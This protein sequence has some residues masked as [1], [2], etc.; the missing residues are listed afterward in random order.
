[1]TDKKKK[2]DEEEEIDY[3]VEYMLNYL[4]KSMKLRMDKWNKMWSIDENSKTVLKFFDK[5]EI[6]KIIMNVNV[7]GALVPLLEFPPNLKTKS[8]YFIRRVPEPITRENI[9]DVLLIGDVSHKPVED[10]GCLVEDM[11]LP[12][13]SNP[14]NQ[15]G[16]PPIIA[17]DVV[18]HAFDF[19]NKVYQIKGSLR[20]QTCL[21]LPHGIERIYESCQTYEANSTIDL[22][23][24]SAVEEI[25]M[26]WTSIINDQLRQS[27]LNAFPN[28]PYPMPTA[29]IDFWNNRLKDLESILDQLKDPRIHKMIQYLELTDSPYL[30]CYKCMYED[31]IA[32]IVEARDIRLY[33]KPLRNHFENLESGDFLDNESK[34]M[35]FTY[36]LGLLWTH[37]KY[38]CSSDRLVNLLKETCNMFIASATIQL[39]SSSIFQADAEDGAQKITKCLK[40]I[41]LF[42]KSFE[43]VREGITT[44]FNSPRPW[45]FHP[46]V[47]FQ[48]LMDF[49]TRIELIKTILVAA[50]EYEKLERFEMP[51]TKG[52]VL[53]QKCE[54]LLED[55]THAYHNFIVITYDP[56]DLGLDDIEKEQKSFMITVH[57]FDLR[58]AAIL[59]QTLEE[60]VNL[61]SIF[62][63]FNMAGTLAHRPLVYN[64][65]QPSLS[66]VLQIFNDEL[67][68]VK[69]LFDVGL[70]EGIPINRF[71]PPVA[72]ALNWLRALKARIFKQGEDLKA[73]D[74]KIVHTPAAEYAF[75]KYDEMLNILSEQEEEFL[76]EWNKIVPPQIQL[77]VSKIQL[78]KD[79]GLL[80][81]N[82]D[83]ELEAILREV[84]L[85]R[86]LEIENICQEAQDVFDKNEE[87]VKWILHLKRIIEWYNYLKTRTLSVEFDIIRSEVE[88]VD[89]K[90]VGLRTEATWDVGNFDLTLEIYLLLKDLYER[91]TT[92]Q[93]NVKTIVEEIQRLGE[94]PLFERKNGDVKELLLTKNRLE[95]I[96]KRYKIIT[97]MS[98]DAKALMEQNY[99]LYLNLFE[100]P[101]PPPDEPEEQE[102]EMVE[103]EKG[104]KGGKKSPKKEKSLKKD[105]SP[106]KEKGKKEK[107]SAEKKRRE[108]EA[109][110]LERQRVAADAA[111]IESLKEK[112]E[113]YEEY[114]DE[115]VYNNLLQ[116]CLTSLEYLNKETENNP[117]V[118][119]LFEISLELH[120]D[121]T[122]YV[123]SADVDDSDNFLVFANTLL[124]DIC[125]MGRYMQRIDTKNEET[126]YYNDICQDEDVRKI[127]KN[128]TTRITT[129]MEQALEYLNV[130]EDYSYLWLD[131]RKQYLRQFL[132]YSRALTEDELYI[133]K[134]PNGPGLKENPPT[135]EQFRQQISFFEKLYKEIETVETKKIIL[136]WLTIDVKP[137]RQAM[138][139]VVAKWSHMFKQHL[140]DRVVDSLEE[141]DQ[142]ITNAVKEL[143]VKLTEEDYDGLIKVMSYLVIIR[144]REVATDLMFEPL[145]DI[146]DLLLEY[147]MQ[148]TE[149]I[150]ILL[151]ELPDKWLTCKK[152]AVT[153]KQVII[154]LQS[155]HISAIRRRIGLFDVRQNIHREKFKNM[156]FFEWDCKNVYPLFDSI[157]MEL[158]DYEEELQK[159]GHQ[160]TLF[161]LQVPEFKLLKTTRLELRL[162]KQLWDFVNV[163]LSSIEEWK[164]TLWKK[165]DVEGM[166]ME[167]KRFAK[168]MRGMEK[169]VKVWII[170]TNME[171]VLKNMM[172]SLRAVTELQNPAIRDRHWVQLMQ[173]TKVKFVLDD[174]TTL[175]DLLDLQ[176]HQYEEE[177]KNI[178]DKS[179]KEM[180]MEKAIKEITQNWISNE[181]QTEIHERTKY[182]LLR[183]TEEQ[184]ELLED[185]QVQLQNML[186]SKFIQHFFS[187]VSEW[188][189]KLSFADQVIG[190]FFEDQRKWCYLESIFIG[191]EDIRSQLPEDSRRF[192]KVDKEFKEILGLLS[193]TLNIIKSTNQT[194]LLTRLQNISDELVLC[195]KA[196]NDYLETKRLAFPRFYFVSSTDLLDILSTGNQPQLVAR[197]LTKL[198]DSLGK[199]KFALDAG[200]ETK[201]AISMGSKENDEWVPFIR[202]CDCSGKVEIWLS[203]VIEVMRITLHSCFSEAVITYDDKPREVWIF[204]YPA[205]PALCGTQIWWTT[206]VNMSFARLEEGYENALK[207]YQK[208]QIAQL[209]ALITLLLGDLTAGDRQKIMTICTIDVHSRDV[210]AKMIQIKVENSQAFQWQSQLRHRWD[211]KAK[212]CLANICDAEFLYQYEYLGNTPRLVITP[213]TD[214]CYITLSQSLHL[215]MGGAPAGPAGTGKTETTKDLGKALGIMVYVFNCSEQMDYKSVGNTYKGLSQTGT[216][217]CF[218]EFNRISVEVLSVVAVQVKTIQD[219]IRT[220]KSVFS[221]LGETVTLIRTV[222]IF[223]TMNPGYAGRTEL[224]ENLKALFRPCAM[225]VPDF[226]LIC[227]I[228]LVAEGF[229]EARLLA[230]KFITLYTLCKELL[231]KQDHYDWGLR[232]IK[233]VLVVAGALRREDRIRPEDQVLM[234][235]LRDFNIPKIVTDDVP[236]FMGLIGDLFPALDVPRKRNYDFEKLAKQSAIELNLQPEDGLILKVVQLEELF[237]VRHSVFV[238]GF[239]GTGKTCVWKTLNRTYVNQKV[240]PHYNDLNPKAVTNDELFGVINPSTREW[241]DGLFS[242]IMRDQANMSGDG[243]KWIVLDGDIDPM[244][245]ESL[246]TLMDDNKVLTL[247]S[248]ERIA[249]TKGMRLLFEI[250]TLRTATPAT[251]SRAGI[252]YIN[253]TDLGWGPYVTSW[254]EKRQEYEKPNLMM[255]FDKYVPSCFDVLKKLKKITPIV[256]IAHIQ[257]L[258][259]LLDCFLTPQN[260]PHECP[261]EWYEI[262][263]VFSIVWA[264]GSSLFQDQLI[265]WRNEFSKWFS[266]EFKSVRFPSGGTVFHYYIDPETKKFMPWSDLTPTFELDADV[267]LQATL[268]NNAE[269]VRVRFFMDQLIS[270]RQPVMLIGSAGSGKTVLVQDKM[271]SLPERYAVT[272]VSF[273]FYTSSEMLQKVL[274]LPLEK[275]AGRVFAPPGNKTMIYFIDDMN[276]PEVDKY[277]TVQPH[278]LLRQWM[279]YQ[280]W[281]DRQKLSLKDIHNILFVSCMNPTAGSFTIDPRLQR[282]FSVF[283]ISFP[284][285][286]ACYHIYSNILEQHFN[287]PQNKFFSNMESYVSNIVNAALGLHAKVSQVFLPTAVK[288]HYTFNLRDLSNIFQ[289]IL[290]SNGATVSSQTQ[291]V[292]LWMHE[293][294]RVYA[295]K[296][297]EK[298]DQDI[299]NRLIL[300]TVKKGF[301]GID[302]ND[303]FTEPLIWCHFA[304][305][306]NDPKYLPVKSYDSLARLLDEAM[307]NYNEIVAAMNLVLF[308]DAMSHICRINRI[309]ESPRGNALLVGVGGSG[310]QSLTRLACFISSLDVFQVQLKKG[311]N[312]TDLKANIAVLYVRAG[313]KNVSTVFLMTDSQVAEEGWLVVIND[314]LASGEIPDLLQDEEVENV[315]NVVR[316][317]VKATGVE[318]TRE[319]CWRF[320]IER[321]RK[322]IKI[323][324]CFSPIG[325]TLRIR[326][327]K[328]PAIVNCTAINWFHEWPEEALESVSE[329]FLKDIETLPQEHVHSVSLFMSYV[330]SVVNKMSGV[331]FQN[332]RRYNYTTPKTFLEQI[333][334]YSKLLGEKMYSLEHGITRLENGLTKLASTAAEVDELQ[335]VLVVQEVVVAEKNAAADK[336]IVVLSVENEKVEAEKA[337]ATE[338]EEKVKLIEEDVTRKARVC[339][340]DLAKAEPALVAA[341][342]ALN[343]LNKNNLTE[344]KSFGSPP[345]A[346]VNVTA[347]VLVLFT[348][349][350]KGK[351]PKDRSWKQCKLIMTKVDQFLNDLMNFDKGGMTPEIVKATQEYVNDPEF[352][353]EVIRAKSIAAAGLCSWVINILKYYD[354]FVVV[355]PKRRALQQANQELDNARSKLVQLNNKLAHLERQLDILRTDFDEAMEAKLK[356]QAEADATALMID[357]A[358]RLVNGLASEKVRWIESVENFKESTITMPGDV[359]LVSAFISYV[360]CFTRRYRQEMMNKYWM[361]FLLNLE[362]PIPTSQELNILQLLTDDAQI[363]KWNN[364]GLPN[365][366]M[367]SEN[368]AILTHSARWPLMIDPQL[369]DII[370][371]CISNGQIVLLENIGETVDAVLDPVLG[372]VLIKKGRC[373]KI[374]DKEV[375]YD[376]RFRLIL[377]TKLANPHY[378]PEIQAQTTLINFTVTRD[379]LEEQLLGD[380]VKSERPDLESLRSSLTKQ[381]NDFKITLKNCEEY[382]LERLSSATGNI[383]GD[384]VL[385]ENLEKTKKTSADIQIKAAEAKITSAR[386]DEAREQYRAAA[387]RGSLLYFILN[388]LNKINA[389]Y[390]FSLKAFSVVFLNA[391]VRAEPAEKLKERVTNLLDSI[392]FM[393]FMYTSRGLFECDKQIFLAQ[394]TFQIFLKEGDIKPNLLDFLLRFP[395]ISVISPVDFLSNLGWGAIKSLAALDEFKQLD[396][397][398][399]GSPNRW[400]KFVESECPERERFPGEWKLKTG[401]ERLCIMRALRPDRMTYAVSVFVEEKLGARYTS[402]R[403]VPFAKSYEE[404]S[405]HTPTFFILSPGVNPLKDVESLGQSLGFAIDNGN[406][407][408]VS[409]G[410]GQEIVA[411]GAIDVAAEKGDWVILENIH[412]VAKWLSNLEK[413]IEQTDEVSNPNYRLYLSAEPSSDPQ[414]CVIPQG[415]L[416]SSIKITNEPPTGMFANLHGALDNFN[417]ETLEMCTKETEFKGILFALCYFHAVV[418]ERRKFGPQGWNRRYPFNIGDLTISVNVLYNYLES[419]SK[420][421]WDDLRYLFGEIMYGGHITDDWDRRL[422]RTYL[423]EFMQ[424]ELIDGDLEL[425]PGFLAPPN[426][427]YEGYHKYIDVILPPESPYLYGLHPNAE[428]GVLT[429]LS[430]NMFRIIFELQPRDA[431]AVTEG[432]ISRE[433]KVRAIIEDITDKLSDPFPIAEMMSKVE[434]RT[435]FVIVAFQ[436][437]ERMNIL[438][439]EMRRSLSELELG[440]KGEL[441]ITPSMETLEQSLFLDNIPET[442][443]IKAYPSMLPLGQWTNDLSLRIRELEN[444]TSDFAMPTAVWLGGFFNPQSFL[445][446]IMQQTARKNEWP[447]D[448]MCL[449]TDVTRKQKDDILFAPREGANVHGL[450]MEGARWDIQS[451][452]IADSKLKDLFPVLPVVYIKAITQD[453]QDLKGL[454]DCPVYKTRLRGPTYVWTFNIKS[455]ERSTKWTMAGVAILLQI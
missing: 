354:V 258:C 296:L 121:Q 294:Y 439:N 110:E 76:T 205:Q 88:N 151:Q 322:L 71:F 345:Q 256:D 263:F 27:P 191:S 233:S 25:V 442:W 80:F 454:Y 143:Q 226:A 108:M 153:V 452:S 365:D 436:E 255:L 235:A 332:E 156:P 169:E 119:P 303:L 154:P 315:L 148:F 295:D 245:I 31:V 38:Y 412:L 336:L 32:A 142:F 122:V 199:L 218:D 144:D 361:P 368:A 286:D 312:M 376:P 147:G 53:S 33:L 265:D 262:Y 209:N 395:I 44:H 402:A 195:E 419:N 242:V 384:V 137:L 172:T 230:R 176:L 302:E 318:D 448:K 417:Q 28:D 85:M 135:T 350:T 13:L 40:I 94:T 56:M 22:P 101:P 123:P 324:L 227:E 260:V 349:Y 357:L 171:M 125:Q 453:K 117:H 288:F 238:L 335:K 428:I 72:G 104:M 323:V 351:I 383:L 183:I 393:V 228:M 224:P 10:I 424:S 41:D 283:A 331:Y 175:S 225:V 181:F 385:V 86:M 34:I 111:K 8:S 237:A 87:L 217:G 162:I 92:T 309:I 433:D 99:K 113:P 49:V 173:A 432:G 279:D 420:I 306:M 140:Y 307:A 15:E 305:G 415:I 406:F 120:D 105:K 438:T 398:I 69:K 190:L 202:P 152:V 277:F 450:F 163:V 12:L 134:D 431:G 390:Q 5:P 129:A 346:V 215:I 23:L 437:C 157:N 287:A 343:T 234:R 193:R 170:F 347:A 229:Q 388:D 222:G 445:T 285:Q 109:E 366:R 418:A 386:I 54:Q 158:C 374:G 360:G 240:K 348:V 326:G 159:F 93:S 246:N 62:K 311:F 141:L 39:D 413:K 400:R 446:A 405:N 165:I 403:N 57:D 30:S 70:K 116:V 421:P 4:M 6:P 127:Q 278:T 130:F 300:E 248:N 291:L 207:D 9:K 136:N 267:P 298:K 18:K 269:T 186:S 78:I 293:S 430:D 67:D 7:S 103:E 208:K 65:L 98:V 337:I 372:R 268:V 16:W 59:V 281:Y 429:S 317:E 330:H 3:R 138:L 356:C 397:D 339:A 341:Q 275:K 95:V 166:E 64:A 434:D 320:Y 243:P 155:I 161:E 314:M 408:T 192:E 126:D 254:V 373:V 250:A 422:C 391:L 394:M 89:E 52:R 370:E 369:Q 399:E 380:V 358:H 187:E 378:K 204:G 363:A 160:A 11:F 83:Y 84:K 249:L 102:D 100:P 344:L 210:V 379:G 362:D 327:R 43:R 168:E 410:Q 407:H 91:M 377:H 301:Q 231:S 381:Q 449:Y 14:L 180:A 251:V 292:S 24:K 375:D 392:S 352:D 124:N 50:V 236:V 146:I 359:L 77:S 411:E 97:D 133:E 196:L 353:P 75:K 364:E 299:F 177:V 416:E 42:L 440:L 241:K 115:L 308:E 81:L 266:N 441:T 132:L 167:L 212:D 46:R 427:D 36:S 35:P 244:W 276:M 131:S 216:W 273:N 48:R 289:G 20:S 1:M 66:N 2:D 252:L 194:G 114:V 203:G 371:R 55:F 274:E 247:A 409:L 68:T 355:E 26:Q 37:S 443:V 214:R 425:A 329:R 21:P 404:T 272:N 63:L 107:K 435:P 389:I 73:F 164:T 297:V 334:L 51:G 223:I 200:K 401:I 179:V 290:F 325:S 426:L 128:V 174:K 261:M 106:K 79:D 270:N 232:A 313:L 150:Y 333:S 82:F 271:N 206:E 185:N 112:W 29:E 451:G 319:N 219:A 60:C 310:K 221:F 189:Q 382:L 201:K 45:L 47:A 19:K 182:K 340:D 58:L 149:E 211:F 184:L 17:T 118:Y 213:L 96:N 264:F 178:V 387:V 197:H 414:V 444:W 328:F 342:A 145:Q 447:L 396:V 338:E 220:R 321:C 316:G 282:H 198:F 239:A 61:E 74:N 284:T 139:N 423:L 259:T 367:S 280:H 455:K 257:M 90:L 188:Q 253:P 304:E